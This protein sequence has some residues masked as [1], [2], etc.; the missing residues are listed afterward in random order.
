MIYLIIQYYYLKTI[1]ALCGVLIHLLWSVLLKLKGM[2]SFSMK[3]NHFIF[4]Y[5]FDPVY[6]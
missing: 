5:I 4:I 2:C 3:K 6:T 1:M